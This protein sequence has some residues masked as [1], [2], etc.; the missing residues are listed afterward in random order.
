MTEKE[1]KKRLK[2]LNRFHSPNKIDKYNRGWGW[3]GGQKEKRKK[4]K[5]KRIYRT[6]QNISIISVFLESL[7]SEFF[8]SLG[9][10]VHLTSP[11]CPPTLCSSLD[12]LWGQ[13]RFQF[14]P[15]PVCSFLQCPQLSELVCFLLWELSMTFYVFH[16]HRVILVDHVDLI[17]SLYS[18]GEGFESSSLA[19]LPLS[20]TSACGWSTGVCSWGCPGGLGF[21]SV[22]ARCGA[23]AA[24]WVAGVLA[25]P[26]TQGSWLPESSSSSL[27]ISLKGW[28]VSMDNDVAS[29]SR[30]RATCLFQASGFLLYFDK[31][32]RSKIWHF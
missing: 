5:S 32:I 20:F 25:A 27:G 9:V 15:F 21:A 13:L 10:T 8:P 18:W 7:L 29:D 28:G 30:C 3:G 14:G 6:S 26:G 12:L 31:S 22:R 4:K 23:G 1:K 11:G 16:R 19:T 2:I 24:A 17:C